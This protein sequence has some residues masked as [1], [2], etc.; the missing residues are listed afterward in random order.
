MQVAK[1]LLHDAN[2]TDKRVLNRFNMFHESNV[3]KLQCNQGLHMFACFLR[4][5]VQTSFRAPRAG[6]MFDHSLIY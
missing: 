3:L 5:I 4:V 6:C 2:V 1:L